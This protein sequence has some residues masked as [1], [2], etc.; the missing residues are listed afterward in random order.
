MTATTWPPTSGYDDVVDLNRY[1]IGDP[2]SPAYRELV[3]V[4]RDQLRGQGV[5]QLTGFLTPAAVSQMLALASQLAAQ[6]WAS[7]QTHTAYFEPADDSASPDH[8]RALLQHSAKKAIA[9]DQIP[10]G[11]PI[12][13]LYESDDLTAFIAAVLGKPVLYRSADPLDALEI[14]I[15]GDGD[16]LGWHFDN[17]E[18]SVTVMYSESQAGGHF[19][20]YPR[21]RDERDENYPGVRKVLLGDPGGVVTLPSSPGTLAVFRGQHALHRVTPVSGPRPRINSVLTYGERPGMKLNRL[22]QELFY[23]RTA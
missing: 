21:L 11:A 5:A 12:R 2:A 13:R 1:P 4:C 7:D 20:Y 18:F 19:D 9:Y 22:T 17:S 6:A 10:A 23:G 16:E 14:A 15:F 8:P 3:R